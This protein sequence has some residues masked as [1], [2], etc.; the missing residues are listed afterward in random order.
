MVLLL[1]TLTLQGHQAKKEPMELHS[2]AAEEHIIYVIRP[3]LCSCATGQVEQCALADT[4][5]CSVSGSPLSLGLIVS[6]HLRQGCHASVCSAAPTSMSNWKRGR[7]KRLL[8][9]HFATIQC[10]VHISLCF[11]SFSLCSICLCFG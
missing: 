6:V 10:Q 1:Q 11:P 2:A 7:G 5:S 8:S 9:F 4:L 3:K